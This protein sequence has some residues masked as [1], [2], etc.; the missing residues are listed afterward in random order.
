ML[1][2]KGE[3][4]ALGMNVLIHSCLEI[5]LIRIIWTLDNFD[6]NYGINHRF[7]KKLMESFVLYYDQHFSF[8]YFLK[9]P[10]VR[11][12]SSKSSDVFWRYRHECVKMLSVAVSCSGGGLWR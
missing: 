8:K 9:I 1:N 7:R 5:S 3:G 6:N 11:E 12:I 2:F 4:V 10:F